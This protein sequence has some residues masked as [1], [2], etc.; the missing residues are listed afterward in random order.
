M[1]NGMIISQKIKNLTIVWTS[2]PPPGYVH[3]AIKSVYEEVQAHSGT[4]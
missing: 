3:K 2:D 4:L 1:E